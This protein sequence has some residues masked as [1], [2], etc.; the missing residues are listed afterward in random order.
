MCLDGKDVVVLLDSGSLVTLVRSDLVVKKNVHPRK[1]AVVCVHGDTREYPV[2]TVSFETSLGNLCHQVGLVPKLP[3]D[4]IVGRDFP[5]FWELWDCPDSPVGGSS[6]PEPSTP[7]S[8]NCED[9]PE[10]PC[11]VL[12]GETPVP[13]EEPATSE[14]EQR[15][16]G[17]D[18]LKLHRENFITEQLRDPT[19][20][21]ARENVVKIDGEL[22]NPDE[23]IAL[24]YFII[25]RD[26]LYRV[27]Q[28]IEDTVEQLVVPK[29]YRKMV[30]ELAHGHILGGHLG[31]EKTRERITQRFY[32][33]G[34]TKEVELYCSSCP[35]CQINAPMPHFR[36]PLVPLPIIEVP[37]ERIAMD[38]VGPLLKSTRGHQH[39][40]VIM[41]YA[42]RYPEAIPLRNTSAKTIAKELF[43]VVTRVGL[44]KEILTD[45]GTP[46]M[47]RVTRELCKLLKVTQLRTSVYHPQTDGLVERF[48]KTLKQMLRKVVDKDG[49]NWDYLL[50]YLMFAIREVPQSST[51]FS[52]F[53]LLYGRH[54]QGL[55]DIARE[56]W[57]S[58]MVLPSCCSPSFDMCWRP[59]WFLGFL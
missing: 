2:T 10:F 37:F 35:V 36:S 3:H 15:P 30:L 44:P 45:Q 21:R 4:A 24:P 6:E 46:F 47:S 41:D 16:L 58:V 27:S 38:L 13:R 56:T 57:E 48:N 7:E 52:P 43:Q 23:R 39:I 22:V 5:K 26:L 17:L 25:E 8:S 54:P 31:A 28:R 12:A 19:L 14:E 9:Y 59:S 11:S 33:P 34:I 20:L 55:L 40:L 53:E 51:G 49:K 42:T 29:P 32:W 50:P 18:D 1:M